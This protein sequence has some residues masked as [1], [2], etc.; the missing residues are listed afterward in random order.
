MKMSVEKVA[1]HTMAILDDSIAFWDRALS[2]LFVFRH[3]DFV[4]IAIAR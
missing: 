4:N 3:A 2:C 1:V